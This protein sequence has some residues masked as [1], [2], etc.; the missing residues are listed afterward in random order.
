M[1]SLIPHPSVGHIPG[2]GPGAGGRL[3]SDTFRCSLARYF[4][5]GF[6][7][8]CSKLLFS[9]KAATRLC[10]YPHSAQRGNG[11]GT[12]CR[13]TRGVCVNGMQRRSS[14]WVHGAPGVG[15]AFV[16][17]CSSGPPPW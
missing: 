7:Q 17:N 16:G 3:D 8:N 10:F 9:C 11:T 2:P 13:K 1:S 15:R 6:V 14:P 12:E 5:A 4:R